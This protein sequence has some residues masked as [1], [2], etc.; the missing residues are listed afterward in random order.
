MNTLNVRMAFDKQ[1]MDDLFKKRLMK[2]QLQ[3]KKTITALH[4]NNNNNINSSISS[5]IINHTNYSYLF[6]AND[7]FNTNKYF[8]HNNTH[9][10]INSKGP[11]RSNSVLEEEYYKKLIK[12]K[13]NTYKKFISSSGAKKKTILKLP[14]HYMN[15]GDKSSHVV[16]GTTGN[17]DSSSLLNKNISVFNSSLGSFIIPKHVNIANHNNSHSNSKI[18]S[19]MNQPLFKGHFEFTNGNKHNYSHKDKTILTTSRKNSSDKEENLMK[20]IIKSKLYNKDKNNLQLKNNSNIKR[21]TNNNN[22]KDN[23]IIIS[24]PDSYKAAFDIKKQSN[25]N[26]QINNL[27]K[28]DIKCNPLFSNSNI[29]IART[30]PNS[31]T[32][33]NQITKIK[34]HDQDLDNTLNNNDTL[35]H[36][37]N[38]KLETNHNPNTS[39]H[40]NNSFDSIYSSTQDNP[41]YLQYNHDMELIRTYIKKYHKK[42]KTYPS[43]KMNFYK[44][45]RLLGKGAFGKVNLGL[46]VLTGRL[47]AIKS[48]NKSKLLSEHQKSKIKLETSIMK[49]VSKCDYVVKLF[50]TFETNKHICIVMEYI[51]AGNLLSYIRKRSKLNEHHAKIIFKQIALGLHHIHS[52]GI[53]HRDIKLDNI[54][55][56]LNNI[57]KICDFGV[58]KQVNANTIMKEQCGT[59]AYMAPELIKGKGYEGYGVDLWSVGVVLYAMLSGTVPFKGNDITELHTAIM[60]GAYKQIEDISKEAEH[61]VRSLLEVDPYKRMNIE[62]V[63][64]HPWLVNVDINCFKSYNLFTN[65][66][67]VLLAKSNVDYRDECN[68]DDMIEHFCV[69]NLDTKEEK[70]K[71]NNNDKSVILAPYNSS[72]TDFGSQDSN[73]LSLNDMNKHEQ[74]DNTNKNLKVINNVIKFTRKVRELNRAYELNNNGEID[75]G[76]VITQDPT[77]GAD[78]NVNNYVSPVVNDYSA[79]QSKPFTPYN[80]CERIYN[81]DNIDMLNGVND[82][83]VNDVALLGYNKQYVVNFIETNEFNYATTTYQLLLKF[84]V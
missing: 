51:C 45:G 7:G 83:I 57:V 79:V 41:K 80:E 14:F 75:N 53:V 28:P 69:L 47:V 21:E 64:Y 16:L 63:L 40:L 19:I 84:S 11:K 36:E 20:L 29:R 73:S 27:N 3:N 31:T 15:K 67:K 12:K 60:K 56:D 78:D 81:G 62:Q 66:E 22:S 70:E 4:T 35:L 77:A 5:S 54:L 48:I 61:L 82:K 8:I 26:I 6:N 13:G 59:P 1:N 76:I 10:D 30:K 34:T 52:N 58:S 50:E 17:M 42:H 43:T 55:I 37:L 49:T 25:N 38:T 65:A 24:I 33:L 74:C 68:K 9:L 32:K 72:R 2:A 23:K 39:S 44:Y 18:S 46:H 71:K